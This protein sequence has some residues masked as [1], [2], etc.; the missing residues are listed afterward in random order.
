MKG[1]EMTKYDRDYI[2]TEERLCIIGTKLANDAF[3][4]SVTKVDGDIVNNLHNVSVTVTNADGQEMTL[5]CFE[6]RGLIA[7]GSIKFVD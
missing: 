5:K 7:D 1:Y 3:S 4:G 6:L 2:M